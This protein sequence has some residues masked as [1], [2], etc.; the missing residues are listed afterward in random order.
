MGQ[1]KGNGKIKKCKS[2]KEIEA[3]FLIQIIKGIYI[4]IMHKSM[5]TICT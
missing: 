5:R 3:L 4:L 1:V 2:L